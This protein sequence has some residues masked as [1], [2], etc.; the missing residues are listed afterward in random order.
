M[1]KLEKPKK[2]IEPKP[3]DKKYPKDRKS[4]RDMTKEEVDNIPFIKD[5]KKWQ[6][7]IVQYEKDL[8]LYEQTK[9]IRLIKNAD[10]KFIL[11]K[12]KIIKRT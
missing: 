2:P 3:N 9:L 12:Y 1:E 6:K 11:K 5:Y 10:I 8:E 4:M 7:D